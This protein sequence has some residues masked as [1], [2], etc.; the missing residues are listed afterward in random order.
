[1]PARIRIYGHEAVFAGGHWTC[2]DDSL[3]AMLEGLADP[4]ALTPQAEQEHATYCAGRFGGLIFTELGWE[5][6]PHPE[7]E[8]KLEDFAP[9]RKPER[10]SSGG[11]GLFGFMRRRKA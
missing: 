11:G 4:R 7:A 1:M 10:E 5:T 8:I 6:A 2:P 9:Q 3:Q